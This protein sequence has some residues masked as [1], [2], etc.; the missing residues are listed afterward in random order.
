[1]GFRRSQERSSCPTAKFTSG[2]SYLLLNSG[3][4]MSV[5]SV[6]SPNWDL[7]V[8]PGGTACLRPFD[9]RNSVSVGFRRS[10]ERSSC[11]T[12]K[13]TSGGSYPMLNSIY[14]TSVTS[15]RSQNWDLDCAY[16]KVRLLTGV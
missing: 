10:Q 8:L 3:V 5:T 16:A 15:V 1:M 11:P 4:A 7:S 14:V 2:G 12:E 9:R 6:R 13:F